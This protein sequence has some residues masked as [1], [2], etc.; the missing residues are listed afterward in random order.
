MRYLGWNVTKNGS[1]FTG[2]ADGCDKL[3]LSYKPDEDKIMISAVGQEEVT[4]Y[5]P[6][7][8]IDKTVTSL[9]GT[10]LARQLVTAMQI[11]GLPVTLNSDNTFNGTNQGV[12]SGFVTV[13]TEYPQPTTITQLAEATELPR[14]VPT[15]IPSGSAY[16]KHVLPNYAVILRETAEVDEP[17]APTAEQFDLMAQYERP[18]TAFAQ[19]RWAEVSQIDITG[20]QVYT[21]SE[22]AYYKDQPLPVPMYVTP[23]PDEPNTYK[24]WSLSV[25]ASGTPNDETPLNTYVLAAFDGVQSAA[26]GREIFFVQPTDAEVCKIVAEWD[27]TQFVI[28]TVAMRN[29]LG[30]NVPELPGY[31]DYRFNSPGTP[32]LEANK[33]YEFTAYVRYNRY[34]DEQPEATNVPARARRIPLQELSS[35]M[36]YPLDLD[37]NSISTGISDVVS[38]ATSPVVATEYINTSGSIS[39]KPFNGVNIIRKRHADGS[40]TTRKAVIR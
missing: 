5:L 2:T 15:A 32:S 21:N 34:A 38:Q 9:A 20:H 17:Q 16:I 6:L 13:T 28:P 23:T 11:N 27:G 36:L 40:I 22:L 3:Y 30:R 25:L 35:Y 37:G 33:I 4:P 12:T 29:L 26:S 8:A 10:R 14:F 1:A 7:Q 39:S 19:H 24:I 18:Y 31:I